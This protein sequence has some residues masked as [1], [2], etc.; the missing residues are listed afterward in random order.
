MQPHQNVPNTAENLSVLR[1]SNPKHENEPRYVIV[2]YFGFCSVCYVALGYQLLEYNYA[3]ICIVV[4]LDESV[5]IY[6]SFKA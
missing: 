6:G 1:L 2:K 4:I 5:V 3:G